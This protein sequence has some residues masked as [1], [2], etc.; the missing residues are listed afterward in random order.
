VGTER[1]G[2]R[3]LQGFGREV[4]K[5][6]VGCSERGTNIANVG[7]KIRGDSLSLCG[8]KEQRSNWDMKKGR[9]RKA[10]VGEDMG[11]NQSGRV[12]GLKTTIEQGTSMC[13]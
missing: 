12:K 9:G 8:E 4:E 11:G 13:E 7:G 5:K 10:S 2:L 6:K 3:V 1:G